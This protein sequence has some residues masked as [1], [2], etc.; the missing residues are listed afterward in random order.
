MYLEKLVHEQELI[1]EIKKNGDIPQVELRF[2]GNQISVNASLVQ[3]GLAR[4]TGD[5]YKEEYMNAEVNG[6]NIWSI[7]GYVN[8]KG[9][10]MG[11]K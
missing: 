8:P 1:L 9:Y 3:E 7:E 2:E 11:I 10:M 6:E 5:D 4:I